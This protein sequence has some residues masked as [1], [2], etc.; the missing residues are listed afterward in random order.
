MDNLDTLARL[1]GDPALFTPA[2][3]RMALVARVA[4]DA[5]D[6]AALPMP[7][8]RAKHGAARWREG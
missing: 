7:G 4:G 3:R 1:G 5:G 2:R 6:G 8:R